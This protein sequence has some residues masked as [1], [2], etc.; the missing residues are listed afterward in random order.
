V[1]HTGARCNGGNSACVSL[2]RRIK[3]LCSDLDRKWTDLGGGLAERD[4]A[5]DLVGV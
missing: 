2:V 4:E 3:N 5:C 1:G